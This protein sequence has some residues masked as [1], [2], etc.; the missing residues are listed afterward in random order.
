[1]KI[2][3]V[4]TELFHADRQT[5]KQTDKKTDKQIDRHDKQTDR[6]DKNVVAFSILRKCLMN[7]KI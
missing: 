5:D 2:Y 1:M 7:Y 6:Y 4:E 3:P